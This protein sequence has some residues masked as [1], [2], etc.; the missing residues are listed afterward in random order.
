MTSTEQ[1]T[2]TSSNSNKPG[3]IKM[4]KNKKLLKDKLNGLIIK[5]VMVL[6][7]KM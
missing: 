2:N 3:K 6:F 7:K 4:L 1:S 5:K